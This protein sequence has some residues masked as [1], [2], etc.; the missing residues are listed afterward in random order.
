MNLKTL[1]VLGVLALIGG[2]AIGSVA[3]LARSGPMERGVQAAPAIGAG[4]HPVELTYYSN[5]STRCDEPL[6]VSSCEIISVH[7]LN[8]QSQHGNC[9]DLGAI[10]RV[11]TEANDL[12]VKESYL[13]VVAR[14][15]GP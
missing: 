5:D 2:V 10:V 11:A 12:R 7:G 13:D 14:W 1:A 6:A 15:K 9:A 8:D 3:E 4:C